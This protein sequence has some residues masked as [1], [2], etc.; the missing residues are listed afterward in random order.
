MSDSTVLSVTW[1]R[2]LELELEKAENFLQLRFER[3]K[4]YRN[5]TLEI[6]EKNR[7]KWMVK[8]GKSHLLD[9]Q[10]E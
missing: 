3:R 1:L 6:A 2:I 7:R 8:Q 10:D 9:F 4:E 5:K